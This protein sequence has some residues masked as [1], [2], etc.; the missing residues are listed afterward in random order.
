MFPFRQAPAGHFC[1]AVLS[2]SALSVLIIF[3]HEK[4]IEFRNKISFG[5]MMEKMKLL[6]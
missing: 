4:H 5:K 2:S 6:D 3:E 1:L